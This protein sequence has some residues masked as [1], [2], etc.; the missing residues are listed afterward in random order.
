MQYGSLRASAM[1]TAALDK[2]FGPA[3]CATW[4]GGELCSG[5]AG[6]TGVRGLLSV[7]RLPRTRV[8]R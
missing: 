5:S 2:Y 7:R 4:R 6:C 8:W 1:K 3:A